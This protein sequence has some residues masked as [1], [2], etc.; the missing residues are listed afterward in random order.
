MPVAVSLL[1]AGAVLCE[2]PSR[3]FGKAP[4]DAASAIPPV[5]STASATITNTFAAASRPTATRSTDRQGETGATDAADG[6]GAGDTARLAN[7]TST[8]L[9]PAV[10]ARAPVVRAAASS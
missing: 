7:S 1:V 5:V 3:G 4:V 10:S 8:L 6:T 9:S 2:V